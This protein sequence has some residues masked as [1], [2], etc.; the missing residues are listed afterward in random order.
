MPFIF[1]RIPFTLASA[2]SEA[3]GGQ[4]VQGAFLQTRNASLVTSSDKSRVF[5]E[6][7]GLVSSPARG[8]VL[9]QRSEG[10]RGLLSALWEMCVIFPHCFVRFLVS[11]ADNLST[12]FEELLLDLCVLISQW[13]ITCLVFFLPTLVFFSCPAADNQCWLCLQLQGLFTC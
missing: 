2:Q 8:L 3:W 13:I 4:E 1:V 6:L 11:F 7:F 9:R 12:I 5:L 10:W